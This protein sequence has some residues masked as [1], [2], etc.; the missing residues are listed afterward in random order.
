MQVNTHLILGVVCWQATTQLLDVPLDPAQLVIAA[1]ASLL[2]DLD[3]P[4]S[5]LGRRLRFISRPL[6]ALVGHRGFTHSLLAIVAMVLALRYFNEG[7][8]LWWLLPLVVGYA[9]HLLGDFFTVAGIPLL[10]PWRM[11]WRSPLTMV[12]G[13]GAERMVMW[14]LVAASVLL[15][16]PQLLDLLP[17]FA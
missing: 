8:I 2:P 6:S 14:L 10:W 15:F 12:T 13:S 11:R 7:A 16:Q 9:S 5:W 4:Q 1:G 17:P 3:H